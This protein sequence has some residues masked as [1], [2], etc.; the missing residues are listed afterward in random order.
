[1][2]LT[3]WETNFKDRLT[4]GRAKNMADRAGGGGGKGGKGGVGG[5]GGRG[6][7]DE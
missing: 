6:A 3:Q 4:E 5:K 1:M 7:T 2:E